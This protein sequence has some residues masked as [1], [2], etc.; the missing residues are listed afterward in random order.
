M[1]TEEYTD[2]QILA[3][4][5]QLEMILQGAKVIKSAIRRNDEIQRE[6]KA[7]ESKKAA[8]QKELDDAATRR[9]EQE[10]KDRGA[11]LKHNAAMAQMD[12]QARAREAELGRLDR[13]IKAAKDVITGLAAE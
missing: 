5:T 7:F 9:L 2:K 3:G 13:D 8:V 6:L 11:R 1:A 4:L 12:E 10:E